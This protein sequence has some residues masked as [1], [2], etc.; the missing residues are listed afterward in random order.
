[1]EECLGQSKYSANIFESTNNDPVLKGSNIKNMYII[2]KPYQVFK[3][4]N[5]SLRL[6]RVGR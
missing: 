6:K 5:K 2:L 1:M 3:M 4:K